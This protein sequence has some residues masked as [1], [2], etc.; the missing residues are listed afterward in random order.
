MQFIPDYIKGKDDPSYVKYAHPLL[1][2]VA[3][4]TYGILVYQ[5]QVMEAA[6]VVAGYTLGGADML[7]RAMG[8]NC[9]LYTSDAADE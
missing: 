3:K 4:E 8:K 1:E 5:E 6:R 9:L 7:R 2:K